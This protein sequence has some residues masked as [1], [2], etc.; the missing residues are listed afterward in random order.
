METGADCLIAFTWFPPRA[1]KTNRRPRQIP[2]V[3]PAKAGGPIRRLCA[4]HGNRVPAFSRDDK[5]R[6]LSTLQRSRR[7]WSKVPP[8]AKCFACASFQPAEHLVDREQAGI[9]L[10]TRAGNARGHHL[11]RADAQG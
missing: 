9:A 6:D 7:I 5:S 4:V 3:T 10:E 11:R 8:S 1:G 2:D